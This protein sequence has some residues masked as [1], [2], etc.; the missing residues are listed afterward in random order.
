MKNNILSCTTGR[1]LL[2][3]LIT[4]ANVYTTS[5]FAETRQFE[6]LSAT[7]N[8]RPE[9]KIL[10]KLTKDSKW[11]YKPTLGEEIV[12]QKEGATGTNERSV[13][14][15][16]R[17][18][19]NL[20]V[21]NYIKNNFSYD[22]KKIRSKILEA[23]FNQ[24]IPLDT[25]YFNSH[26]KNIGFT[27]MRIARGDIFALVHERIWAQDES[28]FLVVTMT[29]HEEQPTLDT[30]N[31]DIER[32]QNIIINTGTQTA[33]IKNLFKIFKDG[34]P[35]ALLLDQAHAETV[36]R[37][38][39]ANDSTRNSKTM[40]LPARKNPACVNIQKSKLRA[41]PAQFSIAEANLTDC[42]DGLRQAKDDIAEYIAKGYERFENSTGA[43][44]AKLGCDK[45]EATALPGSDAVGGCYSAAVIGNIVASG[46]DL[47]Y[48]SARTVKRAVE[49]AVPTAQNLYT[50]KTTLTDITDKQFSYVSQIGAFLSRKIE[51][52]TCLNDN[53]QGKILCAYI[54]KAGAAGAGLAAGA[55]TSIAAARVLRG[56]TAAE[57]SMLALTV[58]NKADAA[59]DQAKSIDRGTDYAKRYTEKPELNKLVAD[60]LTDDERKN[61]AKELLYKSRKDLD[62]KQTENLIDT[63]NICKGE[64]E[65][66][67]WP[68]GCIAKKFRSCRKTFAEEQCKDLM[69]S[70]L[71]GELSDQTRRELLNADYQRLKKLH[72]ERNKYGMPPADHVYVVQN[73]D[74]AVGYGRQ[75]LKSE[76][77]PSEILDSDEFNEFLDV[78]SRVPNSYTSEHAYTLAEIVARA[79]AKERAS[80]LETLQLK[81]ENET[82]GD[83]N[84]GSN[85]GMAL[86]RATELLKDT[87]GLT[88]NQLEQAAQTGSRA[89]NFVE[90]RNTYTFAIPQGLP[91]PSETSRKK[92]L[93]IAEKLR[94]QN[95]EAASHYYARAAGVETRSTVA[96]QKEPLTG[97]AA[98]PDSYTA[99]SAMLRGFETSLSGSNSAAIS[100][101]RSAD[102]QDAKELVKLAV[103]KNETSKYVLNEFK[104]LRKDLS[105]NEVEA[106]NK[107]LEDIK[108]VEA[109]AAERAARL[110]RE[111]GS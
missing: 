60:S 13:I 53:E 76:K 78:A 63:H 1:F 6:V 45:I 87:E 30:S 84:Y 21:N 42:K 27:K 40:T 106:I 82:I 75:I 34:L 61:A 98:A 93:E 10:S 3:T 77:S 58:A 24:T 17:F 57:E 86:S 14:M 19:L 62:P 55:G 51:G 89:F 37:S 64:G 108:R 59:I 100:I 12:L 90:N 97:T 46:R 16:R 22:I 28:L 48:A 5:A 69:E 99:K 9:E 52:F 101:L 39:I 47:M 44:A 7:E 49:W 4:S 50:G 74:L 103:T 105:Q 73:N 92:A 29:T 35:A 80:I 88:R 54:A 94:G 79:P 43:R 38:Q 15:I 26:G 33:S 68:P 11:S 102:T 65:F 31:A 85:A 2:I 81:I 110:A 56:L 66:G 104:R 8:A 72:G 20:D 36:A 83:G 107:R 23:Q 70:G 96:Y 67:R 71:M 25:G 32:I 109:A 91:A 18:D 111:K 41:G 95:D